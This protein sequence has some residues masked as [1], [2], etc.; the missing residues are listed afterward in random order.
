M[1]VR[2]S[3]QHGSVYLLP[4]WFASR[5]VVATACAVIQFIPS[6]KSPPRRGLA[7]AHKVR[8]K[9]SPDATRNDLLGAWVG[10]YAARMDC[11]PNGRS[12][13]LRRY[14]IYTLPLNLHPREGDFGRAQCALRAEPAAS[15]GII[16]RKGAH[17]SRM[18]KKIAG[19]ASLSAIGRSSIRVVKSAY[20]FSF[21]RSRI[22]V[23]SFSSSVGSGAGAGA[24]AAVSALARLRLSELMSLTNMKMQNA[25]IAKSMHV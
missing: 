21:N 20:R 9:C 23:S 17:K 12:Y 11:I 16:S 14:T 6:P 22:S 5:T 4:V 25:M 15:V 19:K 18:P 7:V 13:G 2:R 24:G 8:S 10:I 1:Y 3:N